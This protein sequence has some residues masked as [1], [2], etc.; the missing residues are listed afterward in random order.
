MIKKAMSIIAPFSA[1]LFAIDSGVIILGL[2]LAMFGVPAGWLSSAMSNPIYEWISNFTP[3]INSLFL[4][5]IGWWLTKSNVKEAGAEG[6]TYG[7]R[8]LGIAIVAA[9]VFIPIIFAPTMLFPYIVGKAFVFRFLALALFIVYTILALSSAVYRPRITPAIATFGGLTLVMGISTLFSID[10]YK[11]F[12]G[13]YERMEGYVTTLLLFVFLVSL[14]GLRLKEVEWKKIFAI[15]VGV[16][17]FV[18]CVAWIQYF[19][20]SF[21]AGVPVLGQ[22]ANSSACQADSTL[23]NPIYLGI[24]AA[25]S[26]WLVAYAIFSK[27]A[28][29]YLPILW[30]TLIV[31]LGALVFSG[32]RGASLGLFLGIFVAGL[33]YLYVNN[34]KAGLKKF[35][36]GSVAVIVV[37]GVFLWAANTYSFAQN[38]PLVAKFGSAN[39]LFARINVWGI[40][41]DSW[42]AKPIFGW[43][44]ENF[45][46]AF[47]SYYNPAMYGQE[48]YFDHPHNTY[49][50]WLAMGGI[51]GFTAYV[52]FICSV[53]WSVFQTYKK[54]EGEQASIGLAIAMGALVTYLIHIFFVFDNLTSIMLLIFMIAYFARGISF[55]SLGLPQLNASAL[56]ATA[57]GLIVVSLVFS[58]FS[59]W[60]PIYANKLIIEGMTG[61]GDTV[62]A[63]IQDM[64]N[65][66]N[67]AITLGSFGTY[68]ATEQM[69]TRGLALGQLVGS[70]DKDSA[71]EIVNFNTDAKAN[72]ERNAQRPFDHKAKFAYGIYLYTLGDLNGAEKYFTEALA[73][74][75][76]KQVAMLALAQ[77][78]T[79]KG[80]NDKALSLYKQ[81]VEI[82][83]VPKA[84]A[85]RS[86]YNSLRIQYVQGLMLAGKNDE[87]VAMIKDLLPAATRSDFESL[88]ASMTNVYARQQDM[89]GIINTL[90]QAQQ[91]DPRNVN[92][93]IWLA[94]ALAYAGQYEA[95]AQQIAKLQVVDPAY[96]AQFQQELT[97]LANQG[98][99]STQQTQRLIQTSTQTASTSE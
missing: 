88:V 48:T 35:L 67:K 41:I 81:A 21:F 49:L 36:V 40:A 50:G 65:S 10:P 82:T 18:S 32:T 34:Y 60:Q 5:S 20:L 46:H 53:I 96:V 90:A 16:S 87:A 54:E 4:I 17:L 9:M 38:I 44:Q 79:A 89:R 66:F 85:V 26:A 72:L 29:S 52:A 78:Y 83:P 25:L 11:S 94:R 77:V 74:A 2:L 86:A 22:C 27:K 45:I 12:F 3:L 80:D 62:L 68:E 97:Q 1:I 91:M 42:K 75:P 71:Q 23:G 57:L 15:Q 8:S 92:F 28:Q 51:L 93:I 63:K 70:V 64:H 55:G 24:Y 69:A 59:W 14:V 6:D 13:N 73:L 30:T 43:G 61:K 39:T 84:S 98:K 47:N 7:L 56:R 76:K 58:Y 19:G 99:V 95:S 37:S 31:N 33:I